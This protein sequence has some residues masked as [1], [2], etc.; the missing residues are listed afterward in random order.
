MENLRTPDACFEDLVG[1]PFAPVYTQVGDLRIHHVDEG[2]AQGELVVLMHG[3]PTWGYL[4]RNMIPGL[5]AAGYRVIVPDLVGFGRS[6]K[7]TQQSD[8]SFNQMVEWMSGWLVA[9]DLH[10]ITLFCQDWGGLIGLRLVAA[11]P[12]RFD[13][14][15]ASNT[16]L[17]DG[18]GKPSEA[19]L[20]WQNF[21]ANTPTF[22]VAN[23][24]QGGC[25]SRPLSNDVLAAYDAPFP[26]ESYKAGPRV[27]PSLVPTSAEDPAAAANKLAWETLSQFTKPFGCA[28]ADGDPITAGSDKAFQRRI[29]GTQGVVHTTIVDA[30]HFVQEDQPDALVAY[31][32]SFVAATPR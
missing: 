32:N 12:D 26:D 8:Y 10:N 11:H 27:M 22:P 25:K 16:F 14:V 17:P 28:F 1:W 21:A 3:E 2:Q 6:D 5:A 20:A 29:P 18:D 24:V 15:V 19:F 13:R 7:P 30:S 4:Y 31:I 23:I 9:N